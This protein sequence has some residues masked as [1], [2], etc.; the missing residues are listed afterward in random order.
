MA[1]NNNDSNNKVN[2]NC[3]N[4]IKM[5]VTKSSRNIIMSQMYLYIDNNMQINT[6]ILKVN[7]INLSLFFESNTKCFEGIC[8]FL[9]PQR[10][11]LLSL[12]ASSSHLLTF[13]F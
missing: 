7:Q 1:C 8:E 11:C 5:S 12:S 9:V 2:R 4:R 6:L 10:F 3:K 13:S